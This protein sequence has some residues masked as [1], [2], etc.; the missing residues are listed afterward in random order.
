MDNVQLNKFEIMQLSAMVNN[1]IA[2]I[3]KEGG[4]EDH[5]LKSLQ[6]KFNPIVD[7]FIKQIDY[8][9]NRWIILN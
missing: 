4:N 5:I 8:H 1:K 9:A 6:S 3:E 2:L 7:E